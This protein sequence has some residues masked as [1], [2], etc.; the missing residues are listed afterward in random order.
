MAAHLVVRHHLHHR[1]PGSRQRAEPGAQGS[2]PALR[3]QGRHGRHRPQRRRKT[4]TLAADDEMKMNA[5]WEIVQ[6]RLVRR[7]VAVKNFKVGDS[8][9][10][11]RRHGPPRHRDPA[12]HPDRGGASEIVKYPQGPEAEE[13]AGGDPGRSGARQLA[14][15]GRAAGRDARRCATTTSASRCSSATTARLYRF[16][17]TSSSFF[18]SHST[19]G[20]VADRAPG[21]DPTADRSSGRAAAALR[22][23]LLLRRRRAARTRA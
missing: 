23:E 21:S 16:S 15:E 8:R 14:V 18:S 12:G 11:G 9:A 7:G 22:S 6:T 3:L 17:F 10:G 19:V 5:L 2:R 13:G 20:H 4:L 1:F